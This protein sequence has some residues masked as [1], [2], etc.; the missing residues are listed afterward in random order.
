MTHENRPRDAIEV[1][2]RW[3]EKEITAVKAMNI[4]G[5]KKATFYQRV[6]ELEGRA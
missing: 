3:K 2:R 6:K 4:T 1:Y 5:L